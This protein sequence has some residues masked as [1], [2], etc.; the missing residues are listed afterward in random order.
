MAEPAAPPA[1]RRRGHRLPPRQPGRR[2]RRRSGGSEHPHPLSPEPMSPGVARPHFCHPPSRSRQ[3]RRR[4]RTWKPTCCSRRPA[5]PRCCSASTAPRTC[6]RVGAAGGGGGD[7][8]GGVGVWVP[9]TH[10]GSGRPR[11]SGGGRVMPPRW[12]EELRGSGGAGQLRRQEGGCRGGAGV[13]AGGGAGVL[14]WVLGWGA[15]GGGSQ[16]CPPQLCTRVMPP[17][18]NPVWNEVFFFPLRVR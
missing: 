6:R 1:P 3:S 9:P 14:G 18:A 5:P 16:L 11:S 4:T 15:A 2:P 10:P 13:G 7:E 17:D 12:P 8:F